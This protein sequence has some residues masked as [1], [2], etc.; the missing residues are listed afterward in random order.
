MPAKTISIVAKCSDMFSATILD[1]KR[2]F[3]YN[4]YVPKFFP[5]EHYG[6][7]VMLDIDIESGKILNW[8][9]PTEEQI[10]ELKGDKDEE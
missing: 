2:S 1:G 5:G 6:D 9:T 8:K 4:G 3:E 7:Y 10:E